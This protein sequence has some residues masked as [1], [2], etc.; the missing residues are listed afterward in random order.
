MTKSQIFEEKLKYTSEFKLDLDKRIIYISGELDENMGTELKTKFNIINTWWK[1]IEKNTF[2]DITIDISSMGGSIYAITGALDFYYELQK[3][4]KIKV[5]TKAQGICMSAATVILAGGTGDRTS[6][7]LSKFL[8]HDIQT[9]GTGGTATQV[10]SE[11]RTLS[12]EQLE[13]FSFYAQFS[14]KGLPEL[15]KKELTREA[16]K[17]LKKFTKG[18]ADFYI[19]ADEMLKL[20]LIDKIL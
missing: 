18:G 19:S 20:K 4:Y 17:W 13:L 9:E 5:N 6:L 10:L 2:K 7:P 11:A 14:R 1:E 12:K 8:L 15:S 3:Y 16:K